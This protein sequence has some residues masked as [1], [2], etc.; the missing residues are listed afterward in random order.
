M[1]LLAM[2]ENNRIPWSELLLEGSG[3]FGVLPT[4]GINCKLLPTGDGDRTLGL[5]GRWPDVVSTG[6]K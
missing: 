5:E 1:G 4:G 6:G 3:R 2:G